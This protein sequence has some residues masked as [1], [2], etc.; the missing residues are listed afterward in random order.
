MWITFDE[1]NNETWPLPDTK[2]FD[3][4]FENRMY[5]V[6]VREDWHIDYPDQERQ[7]PVFEVWPAEGHEFPADLGALFDGI[8]WRT[9]TDSTSSAIMIKEANR[10]WAECNYPQGVALS[11]RKLVDDARDAEIDTSYGFDMTWLPAEMRRS[12]DRL[13]DI[14]EEFIEEVHSLQY[15]RLF[16]AAEKF[17]R[18]NSKPQQG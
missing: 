4:L 10:Y 5:T 18:E 11:P 8:K 2:H 13:W 12:D 7:T 16:V 15:V 1:R 17:I 9:A 3:V 6:E 14:I